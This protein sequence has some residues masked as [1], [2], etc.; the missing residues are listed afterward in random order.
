MQIP[1]IWK[2]GWMQNSEFLKKVLLCVA[3]GG[4]SAVQLQTEQQRRQH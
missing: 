1:D 3:G 2:S 4:P